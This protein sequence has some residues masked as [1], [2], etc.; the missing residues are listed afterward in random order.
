MIHIPTVDAQD[1]CLHTP[2][3]SPE[4]TQKFANGAPSKYFEGS[5]IYHSVFSEKYCQVW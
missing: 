5:K 1:C 2:L 4:Q 3:M